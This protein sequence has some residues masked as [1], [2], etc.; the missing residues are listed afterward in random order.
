MKRKTT[1]AKNGPGMPERYVA[2]FCRRADRSLRMLVNY[3]AALA[4][5]AG[6]DKLS[7]KSAR[8]LAKIIGVKLKPGVRN[9]HEL[10]VKSL[11]LLFEHIGDAIEDKII[12]TLATIR[13]AE[14]EKR[15]KGNKA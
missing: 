10:F 9:D 3:I 8:T 5:T 13:Y 11:D 2:R 6:T 7:N 4:V 1:R 12:A 15:R 14:T